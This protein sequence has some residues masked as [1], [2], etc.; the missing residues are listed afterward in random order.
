MPSLP[1]RR[2]A[3]AA[4]QRATVERDAARPSAVAVAHTS[5]MPGERRDLRAV[6]A[7]DRAPVPPLQQRMRPW[8]S[9]G[10]VGSASEPQS[11]LAAMRP[12]S[13]R[14]PACRSKAA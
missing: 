4:N 2:R 12:A 11:R 5:A 8:S 7:T 6:P 3:P 13:L 1:G 10:A 9:A 14:R